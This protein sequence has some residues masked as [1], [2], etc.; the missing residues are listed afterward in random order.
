DLCC[1]RIRARRC[2]PRR[3]RGSSPPRVTGCGSGRALKRA[4]SSAATWRA[5]DTGAGTGVAYLDRGRQPG[6]TMD[7]FPNLT[8]IAHPLIQHKLAVL[9]DRA[10]SKNTFRALVDEI[11]MLM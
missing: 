11:S 1:A 7:T 9:R 4:G 3:P 10:T 2:P 8:V 6:R 5:S